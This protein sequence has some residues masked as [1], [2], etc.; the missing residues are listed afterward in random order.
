MATGD[1]PQETAK[2]VCL[3]PAWVAGL[4]DLQIKELRQTVGAQW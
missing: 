2:L 4:P 3:N 1:E